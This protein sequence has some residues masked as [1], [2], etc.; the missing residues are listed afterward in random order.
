MII[1]AALGMLAGGGAVFLV[2]KIKHD[3]DSNK[4]YELQQELNSLKVSAAV[5]GPT[6]PLSNPD[7]MLNPG[8]A[9]VWLYE[10]QRELQRDAFAGDPST[11]DIR[12]K[13]QYIQWNILGATDEL[14]EVLGE[15]QWKMWT[16]RPAT[17]NEEAYCDELAD[18]LHL[19]LNLCLVVDL[20]PAELVQ[21]Y[22][23]KHQINRQRAG[24][25]PVSLPAA[26]PSD[27]PGSII[28]VEPTDLWPQDALTD[29]L[30]PASVVD[31]EDATEVLPIL[32]DILALRPEYAAYAQA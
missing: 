16:G 18:V 24:L 27:Q 13:I 28:P 10:R 7:V 30:G 22:W 32:A 11:F 14:H 9:L 15:V 17:I 3:I 5:A 1:E 19:F 4:R 26:V 8:D 6:A 2:A 20:T 31:D 23:R 29:P 25:P 21:R 12:D